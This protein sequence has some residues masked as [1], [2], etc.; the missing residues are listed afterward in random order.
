MEGGELRAGR[1]HSFSKLSVWIIEHVWTHKMMDIQQVLDPSSWPD[2]DSQ[3][4]SLEDS[5]RLRVV[6]AQVY[7]IVKSRDLEHFE[8]VMGFLETMYRLLPRLVPAIKHMKIMFGIKT[9]VIMWMLKEGW[10]MVDTVSKIGQFFPSKLP[11]YQ[12]Q[13]SQREMFLMRKNHLDFRTLAQTLAMDKDKLE[14]YIKNEMEE[15]Y[16]ERYAQKVEDRLLHYLHELDAVLQGDTYIDKILKKQSPVTEEEKL[17][18]EVIRS[19]STTI[20]ATLKKLLH[21]DAASCRQSSISRSPQLFKSAPYESSSKAPL[22]S[23]E[24][25][26]PP[27]V[28]PEEAPC[29]VSKDGDSFSDRSSD[30][31][32]HQQPE[33]EDEVNKR[34]EEEDSQGSS[35]CVQ[36][37]AS[38][39]QFC[40]KHQRWVKSILLGCSE[41]LLLQANVSSSP[42]LFPSSS[43]TSS[44][45]DLTPSDLIP[46]P[47]DQPPLQT[48]SPPRAAVQASRTAK[49]K[50]RRSSGSLGSSGDTSQAQILPQASSARGSPLPALLSPVVRLVNIGSFETSCKHQH[51]SPK[52]LLLAA[53]SSSEMLSSPHHHTSGNVKDKNSSSTSARCQ[54]PTERRKLRRVCS[55]NRH[56]EDLE[57]FTQNPQQLVQDPSASQMGVP[58][59]ASDISVSGPPQK[60]A[61]SESLFSA[62]AANQIT[63]SSKSCKKVVPR[64]SL[65]HR[66]PQ[67]NSRP[68][69]ETA[70]RSSRS[71]SAAGRSKT[72]RGLRAQLRLSL[73]S[74]GV[75]LH[76]KLLQ[77]YVSLTRLSSEQCHLSTQRTASAGQEEL[78]EQDSDSE[79]RRKEEEEDLDSSFDVNALF[80]TDSSS[81]DGEESP[82]RDPDYRPH[83]KKKRLLLEYENARVL[84]HGDGS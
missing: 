27:D 43:S 38:T 66:Q 53:S 21:C 79:E 55:T 29:N 57:A 49:P 40:S 24:S 62:Y 1:M 19:D 48:P 14:H 41:E 18:L 75:L 65:R 72:S 80:S 31:R 81:S 26:T 13:C 9:M 70:R 60:G 11:E 51:A 15:Q 83:I 3:P 2:V 20:A 34:V 64:S 10:G 50:Y 47:P 73:P 59:T 67:N 74:Q 63:P 58:A 25:Q 76:S 71:S 12:D 8:R 39:P 16:G 69:S 32:G 33:E 5:W 45:Q 77:P 23:A 68:R 17:L 46:C 54:T 82:D 61:Q 44:S 35:T 6:S 78:V 56:K 52:Q 7:S 30:I 42:L 37:A 4:L 28:H 84:S 36:E 22:K